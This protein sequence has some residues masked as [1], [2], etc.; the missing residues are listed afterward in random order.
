MNDPLIG[1]TLGP[2]LLHDVIGRGGMGAVYLAEQPNLRRTVAIKV[3]PAALAG[4]RNFLLRFRREATVVAGLLHP[5]IVPVYDYG[6]D[7]GVVYI[8][9]AYVPGGTLRQRMERRIDQITAV[10]IIAQ[11]ASALDYAHRAGVVHRDIKPANILLSNDDWALLT[12]FGIASLRTTDADRSNSGGFATPDYMSPEQAIGQGRVDGRSDLYSLGVVLYELLVGQLPFQS[13]SAVGMAKLHVE[14]TP[15]QPRMY[16]PGISAA[17]EQVVLKSLAKDPG[18]RYQTGAQFHAALVEATGVIADMPTTSFAGIGGGFRS[19]KRFPWMVGGAAAAF[20]AGAIALAALSQIAAPS[21]DVQILP[22][23]TM[24]RESPTPVPETATPTVTV[25]PSPSATSPTVTVTAAAVVATSTT[26]PSTPTPVHT[27][28]ALPS[29]SATAQPSPSTGPSVSP[30][31]AATATGTATAAATP[32]L[33]VPAETTFAGL[34]GQAQ[35]L[36]LYDPRLASRDSRPYATRFPRDISAIR[37]ELRATFPDSAR[38]KPLAL[39]A[40]FTGPDGSVSSETINT[41]VANNAARDVLL[42]FE[43]G[44]AQ[45]W[46]PGGWRLDIT[47]GGRPVL[48]AAFVIE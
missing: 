25:E 31:V 37:W 46:A 42:T 12:D 28:T 22:S 14:A 44:R 35:S 48:A 15:P 11:M 17:L 1:T 19:S 38:G 7:S 3:L 34:G 23:P 40:T 45:R 21:R 8:V 13:D 27:S 18:R 9:M 20:G 39:T 5:N 29:P 16:E 6:E 33:D 43:G 36:L 2:Y 41:A 4:D 26:A 24:Y 47:S 32:T 10:R 30:T